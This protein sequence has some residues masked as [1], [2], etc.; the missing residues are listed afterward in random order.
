[1]TPEEVAKIPFKFVCH[2]S[3]EH[4]HTSTYISEDGR[5]G[6]CDHQP[7]KNGRPYGRSYRHFRID[8]EIYKT[9]EK[10]L[11]AMKAFDLHVFIKEKK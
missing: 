11:E 9:K 3:M 8:N 4:E 1:M 10:F 7:Y 6:F 2:M 5:L